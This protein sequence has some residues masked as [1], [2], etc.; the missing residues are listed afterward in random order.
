MSSKILTNLDLSKN[1]L[2]NAVIQKVA[3]DPSTKLMAG[4]VAVIV[5]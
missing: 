1:Q 4:Y 3:S 2:L 5:V